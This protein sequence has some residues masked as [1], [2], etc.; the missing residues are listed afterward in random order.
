MGRCMFS[1]SLEGE[2]VRSLLRLHLGDITLVESVVYPQAPRCIN[3]TDPFFI[4]FLGFKT[5]Q[6]QSERGHLCLPPSKPVPP[7]W[8]SPFVY[9][10]VLL[11]GS[12]L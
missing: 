1:V 11:C 9:L 3:C 7:S 10:F 8:P 5:G 4:W 12:L 6:S 2:K